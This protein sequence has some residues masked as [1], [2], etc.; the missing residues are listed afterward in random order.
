MI[1]ATETLRSSHLAPTSP[2]H[3][4]IDVENDVTVAARTEDGH[5]STIR[6]ETSMPSYRGVTL[7]SMP[8]RQAKSGEVTVYVHS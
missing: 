8:F 3:V 2:R 5:R 6:S 1:V 4:A 7:H